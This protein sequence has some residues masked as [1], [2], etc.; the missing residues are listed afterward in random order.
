MAC[1][2]ERGIPSRLPDELHIKCGISRE[3]KII[4]VCETKAVFFVKNQEGNQEYDEVKFFAGVTPDYRR[5]RIQFADGEALEGLAEERLGLLFDPGLCLRPLDIISNNFLVY[6]PKSSVVDFHI[7][8]V[9]DF[10][11][12]GST[13]NMQRHKSPRCRLLPNQEIPPTQPSSGP[14]TNAEC[15]VLA[16]ED[17]HRCVSRLRSDF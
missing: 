8:R 11:D 2:S 14:L 15:W 4:P 6:I 17:A 7:T 9:T 5:V 10:G 1:R 3:D 13:R 16:P 12:G